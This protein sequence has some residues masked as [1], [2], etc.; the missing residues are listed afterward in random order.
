MLN[1]PL[2]GT[3]YLE[4]VWDAVVS[5]KRSVRLRRLASARAAV[6]VGAAPASQRRSM[7]AAIPLV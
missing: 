1:P 7:F 6:W 4:F 5:A 2:M 3:D